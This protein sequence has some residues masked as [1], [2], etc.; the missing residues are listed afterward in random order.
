[1][2]RFW[3]RSAGPKG[4]VGDEVGWLLSFSL[5]STF[6]AQPPEAVAKATAV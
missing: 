2:R 6:S 4:P 5:L 1:M 3:V